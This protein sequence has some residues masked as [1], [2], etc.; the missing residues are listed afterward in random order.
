M[1]C[2]KQRKLFS[3]FLDGKLEGKIKAAFKEHLK[4]CNAC[5]NEYEA[6]RKTV[7]AV[8]GLPR[9]AAP[10]GFRSR[11]LERV[12][13]AGE[14]PAAAP[15][16]RRPFNFALKFGLAGSLAAAA[17]LLVAILLISPVREKAVG[18]KGFVPLPR[19]PSAVTE[20]P[21]R[22]PFRARA[23]VEKEELEARPA[24]APVL[25][26][27]LHRAA[28]VSKE[29]AEK[30]EPETKFGYA[31]PRGKVVEG[32]GGAAAA[33]A[34]RLA[35]QSEGA[36]TFRK[37]E[38]KLLGKAQALQGEALGEKGLHPSTVPYFEGAK[39]ARGSLSNLPAEL[40]PE[41]RV[42]IY[43]SSEEGALAN[44]L[45][46]VEEQHLPYEIETGRAAGEQ[47][48]GLKIEIVMSEREY[49]IYLERLAETKGIEKIRVSAPKAAAPEKTEGA[50]ERARRATERHF[51]VTNIL[52]QDRP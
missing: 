38:E 26:G 36:R 31:S 1:K 33:F 43:L 14:H 44:A 28:A 21:E 45:R 4:Q 24:G 32:A 30:K 49:F 9:A 19:E 11:V 35:R 2:K 16:L 40:Y 20:T 10:E 34:D 29:T 22:E 17:I 27:R 7:E 25:E 5:R 42:E 13:T 37:T 48:K 6:F 18:E 52:N 12:R 39:Y 3:A 8:R 46:I 47:K 15:P 51:L 41:R 50:P 23:G